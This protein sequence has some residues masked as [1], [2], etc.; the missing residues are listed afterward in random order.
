V[1]TEISTP[2]ANDEFSIQGCIFGIGVFEVGRS[3]QQNVAH[4]WLAM[5]NRG[6]TDR[7][8]FLREQRGSVHNPTSG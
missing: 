2:S 6:A 8:G 1:R 5:A 4:V 7:P 3:L